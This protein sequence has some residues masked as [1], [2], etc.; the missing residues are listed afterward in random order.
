MPFVAPAAFRA[1]TCAA[2]LWP[3]VETRAVS[4][5]ASPRDRKPAFLPVMAAS[6]F[7]KSRVDRASRS[8]RVTTTPHGRLMLTMLGGLA[9]F[10]REL[11]P[12]RIQL[13]GNRR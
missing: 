13:A 1:A 4:A 3:S 9:E 8:N 11:V 12:R 6:V 5:Q 10:E 2:T 7:S